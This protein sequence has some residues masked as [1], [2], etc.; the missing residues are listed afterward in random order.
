VRRSYT[1]YN[2]ATSRSPYGAGI[3]P[4]YAAA[5][6]RGWFGTARGREIG[7]PF[8]EFDGVGFRPAV[9][10]CVLSY[11]KSTISGASDSTSDDRGVIF[12]CAH[13]GSRSYKTQPRRGARKIPRDGVTGD[14]VMGKLFIRSGNQGDDP[15]G[16][17]AS[18][19]LC[20]HLLPL[21]VACT[22]IATTQTSAGLCSARS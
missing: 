19:L 10:F 21:C 6:E 14:N 4:Y 18:R 11:A 22:C 17:R 1:K 7:A 9:L 8:V 15:N 2:P 12:L 13:R 3:S 16:R 5:A 20:R